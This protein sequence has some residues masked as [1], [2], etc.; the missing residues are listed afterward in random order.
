MSRPSGVVYN[1]DDCPYGC[2]RALPL[3]LRWSATPC[4]GCE[5]PL[6][7]DS[8][9]LG[10]DGEELWPPADVPRP[11]VTPPAGA[12]IWYVVGEQD[13]GE[14]MRIWND[15]IQDRLARK[16]GCAD[17]GLMA[18][19]VGALRPAFAIWDRLRRILGGDR[20]D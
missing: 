8:A 5:R 3:N 18:V 9:I 2:G 19:I 11:S 10:D 6:Y 4:R 15:M 13:H 17:V 20:T 14:R 12:E 7:P 16:E 1:R